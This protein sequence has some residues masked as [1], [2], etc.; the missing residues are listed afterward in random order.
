MLLARV[1]RDVGHSKNPVRAVRRMLR[2]EC[3]LTVSNPA[4]HPMTQ[5][6]I[7]L[8]D[9]ATPQPE[10]IAR[11]ASIIKRGGLVAFPTETVY[12][13][14]ADATSDDAVRR[15]FDAK[16]RPADNP[17]II[18]VADR[19]MLNRVAV[20]IA[21][22]AIKLI[23]Q[24]WPGPLTLVLRRAPAIAPSVSAGLDTVA[25][26]MPDAPIALA[27]IRAAGIPIAAPS[28]NTSGR[29]SPTSAGHVLEDLAG[30]VDMILDGGPAA[31]GIESTV[32]DMTVDPPVILRPGW[33]TRDAIS[34]LIGPVR[35]TA[36]SADL[37]RS[38]GTRYK[39]YS[40]RARVVLIQRGSAEL[41]RQT[42]L[43]LLT[44]GAVAYLGHTPSGIS[45]PQFAE[46]IIG[47]ASRDYAAAIYASLRLLDETN[48]DVIVVQGIEP[49]GEGE[50]VMDRL[51]RAASEVILE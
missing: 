27:L 9:S 45:H 2:R 28:A 25:V 43:D 13:L 44:K 23:D 24:F 15:I 40:P 6:E 7:L 38:P 5:T 18:H 29:P 41:I 17:L 3:C 39:H 1:S 31:I 8:I 49:S 46:M 26:R 12:G 47:P 19:Q 10:L 22:T 14:G 21:D 35:T 33:V 32:I 4:R 34:D 50:A 42:C 36:S 16:G 51:K 48:P 30:Q 37:G 11:A 20:D